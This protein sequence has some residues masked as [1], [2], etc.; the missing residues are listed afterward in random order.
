M[1]IDDIQLEVAGGNGGKG[2]VA[3]SKVRLVKGPTGGDGGSGGNVYAEGISDIN[4]LANYASRREVHA[5]NGRDGR[6]KNLDGKRG[7]DLIIKIPAGTRITNLHNGYVQELTDIGQKILL[8][9]GGMGGKGNFKYRSAINTTPLE[10]QTGLPG[11]RITFQFELRLIADIGLIG[12]PNAGKSSLLNELT[13]AQSKVANYAFTTLEPSLGAYYEL[14]LADIPGLI[15]GASEGKGLGTKFLR[16]IERTGT[17][18]HLVAADSED[19]VRDYKVIRGE[20][21]AYSESLMNKK[22]YVF[23]SKSDMVDADELQDKIAQ[24]KKTGIEALPLSVIDSEHMASIKKLLNEI[25]DHK[26]AAAAAA[27]PEE[28]AEPRDW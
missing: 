25:K 23:L 17:L 9:G 6:G 11:D 19:V 27:V 14:I 1:L 3:F 16:H 21:E 18:F 28:K 13:R 4:A 8:A 20:L 24:L 15:E 2:A 7:E 10:F 22:E 26:L 12:L 5:D